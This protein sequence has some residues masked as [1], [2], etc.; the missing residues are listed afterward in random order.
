MLRACDNDQPAMTGR[1]TLVQE[2][3]ED[4]QAGFLVY[5]PLYRKGLPHATVLERRT[6]LSVWVTAVF[7][8]NDLMAGLGHAQ[9]IHLDL[10]LYDGE[11]RTDETLM[12]DSRAQPAATPAALHTIQQIPIADR[13]W[14]AVIES[15]P[16]FEAGLDN[17]LPLV[18]AIT[19]L[20]FSFLLTLLMHGFLRARQMTRDLAESEERWRYAL[21]G[22]GDGVWDWDI[23]HDRVKYSRNWTD[24]LG[25][26]ADEIGSSFSECLE[27]SH[28]DD[29]ASIKADIQSHLDGKTP[30]FMNEHRMQHKDGSWRWILDR[31]MVTS[32]AEDGTPVRMI[33]T[34][35]DITAR[36]QAE[37]ALRKQRDFTNA[38]MEA[39][40]NVILVL[41]LEGRFVFFNRAAENLTGYRREELIGKPVWDWVIPVEQ[42]PAVKQVFEN[43]KAGNLELASRYENDWLTRDGDHVTLDWHNTILHDDQGKVTHVVALGYDIMERRRSER[44]IRRLTRLYST[45]SHCDQAI[46][47]SSSESELFP[48]ICRDA[49]V[50]GG[51]RLAWIGLVDHTSGKVRHAASY[52]ECVEYID[53]MKITVDAGD[54][55]GRGPTGTA[56]RENRPVWC[57]DCRNDPS[58][59][60]WHAYCVEY[61]LRSSAA[62]PLRVNGEA[63]GAFTLHSAE[64]H[65]FD[66]DAR[67]LLKQMATDISFALDTF[68][69]E[70][71]RRQAEEELARINER[72]ESMVRERTDEL[73][74]AKE[75][76]DAA[77]QAKS[78]FLSNMSHEIRT[79]LTAIIGFSEALLSNNYDRQ[80]HEKLIRTIVRNGKHLQKIIN[81][82]LDL[83]KIEANHL[84]HEL[85]D[86]SLFVILAEIQSLL[87]PGAREKGLDFR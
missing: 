19:G 3:D 40:G 42:Q 37:T 36:K 54:P 6:N 26:D 86:T 32:R 49:V 81:D 68:A 87:R 25:Y 82:I 24:M 45:L 46:V 77:S 74:Q 22:A 55:R 10:Q 8:M 75:L 71:R 73:R 66:D 50:H 78:D 52:G 38:V 15:T 23:R 1:L 72:L 31:G 34:H 65:A 84:E 76:A 47:H 7:R 67:E 4:I 13:T 79:P 11:T 63:I 43:L 61:D 56:I 27:H 35:A 85:A 17:R 51:Y 30:T 16:A 44:R 64:A 53:H 70:K 12:F 14:T 5:M 20:V 28:P 9:S 39:A 21:E 2:T 80:E 69:R 60:P 29:V 41:D 62:L 18:T 58:T 57:Q 83:S 48:Q 33:G 59:E